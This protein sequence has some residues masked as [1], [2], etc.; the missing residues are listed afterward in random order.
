MTN[1]YCESDMHSAWR[2]HSLLMFVD[3]S[4]RCY[5]CLFIVHANEREVINYHLTRVDEGGRECIQLVKGP[6]AHARPY[7]PQIDAIC[8]GHKIISLS[9]SNH[10]TMFD[11]NSE[12]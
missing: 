10:L 7:I 4:M 2:G 1:A 5:R 8:V 9:R 11:M 12:K 3:L 6:L